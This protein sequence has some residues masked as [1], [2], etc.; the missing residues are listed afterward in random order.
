MSRTVK[1]VSTGA[2]VL[3][4]STLFDGTLYELPCTLDSVIITAYTGAGIGTGTFKVNLYDAVNSRGDSFVDL[5]LNSPGSG[6]FP[7]ERDIRVALH[8][9]F[10]GA[11]SVTATIR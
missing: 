6:D 1:K 9:V 11:G 8:G 4:K 5:A 3:G 7:L 2:G 10:T